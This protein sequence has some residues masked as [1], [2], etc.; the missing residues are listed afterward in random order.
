MD[1][2]VAISAAPVVGVV[3]F[4]GTHSS[5]AMCSTPNLLLARLHVPCMYGC[6]H[7]RPAAVHLNPQWACMCHLGAGC[8]LQDF[9]L[10]P[11]ILPLVGT[12]VDS[13]INAVLDF[14]AGLARRRKGMAAVLRPQDLA[15]YMSRT[16]GLTVPGLHSQV[17]PYRRPAASELHKAR[18]AAV[19]QADVPKVG[20]GGAG[21][22]GAA[23]AAEG[24]GRALQDGLAGDA[25]RGGT[26][27]G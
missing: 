15:A 21:R 18:A 11:E 1:A 26:D 6:R 9:R 25:S 16:Y 19:R 8:A 3:S 10:H 20:R 2:T 13:I 23:V 27:H 17:V 14:G 12:H 24:R 7:V 4:A 22:A 5:Q